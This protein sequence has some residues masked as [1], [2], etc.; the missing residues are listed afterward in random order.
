MY[1]TQTGVSKEREAKKFEND[2]EMYGTQTSR[3]EEVF[4]PEF[5]NDVE[6][7]G[8][9]TNPFFLLCR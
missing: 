4:L 3:V 5:E 7:Y 9:Q 6:M 2:V 8:T 1:G